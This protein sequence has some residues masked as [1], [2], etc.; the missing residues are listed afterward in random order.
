MNSLER[1]LAAV[2]FAQVDRLPLFLQIS[3]F[4]ATSAGIAL[5]E[6]LTKSEVLVSAQLAAA[7]RFQNDLLVAAL[8][9]CVEAEALGTEITFVP[10]AYPHIKFPLIDNWRQIE[11]LSIPDPYS[12][13]R[14]P[15]LLEACQ[16]LLE[17][18]AG[19]HFVVGQT[20]GPTTLAAQIFGIENLMYLLIDEPEGFS[21]LLN[22]TA[23]VTQTLAEVLANLGVHGVMIN[24]PSA[25]PNI[26][27]PEVFRVFIQPLLQEVFVTLR[28]SYSG[29]N[30]LQITGNATPILPL[31]D[32]LEL[33]LVTLD[34]PVELGR[35]LEV[36]PRKTLC[37]NL[38]P[39][40][41]L[42]GRKERLAESLPGTLKQGRKLGYI[43]GSGCEIP[44][45]SD[46][47]N[48]EYLIELLRC[49]HHEL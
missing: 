22:F 3:G 13:G 10:E 31:I 8:D 48:L 15:V 25:S 26:F 37:G 14:L 11:D 33:D 17:R 27:P 2:H 41:F 7:K 4:A 23:Q 9:C 12:A 49:R 34:S 36:F 24:E 30:W 40:L 35:A 46:P 19:E 20:L 28:R 5:P 38:N 1:V 44:L 21:R 18:D 45:D 47:R 39:L 43:L 16:M 42:K 32:G 29:V 6:Y